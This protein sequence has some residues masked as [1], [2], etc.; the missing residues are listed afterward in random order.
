MTINCPVPTPTSCTASG[1]PL[2]HMNE[3][4]QCLLSPFYTDDLGHSATM[5]TVLS[6]HGQLDRLQHASRETSCLHH[7]DA[8]AVRYGDVKAAY[9]HAV[10]EHL[11]KDRPK[12]V[13]IWRCQPQLHC[14]QAWHASSEQCPQEVVGEYGSIRELRHFHV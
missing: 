8:E 5:A 13:V 3:S 9:L 2:A 7:E 4:R 6:C 12:H 14:R 1:G 11:P 10:R